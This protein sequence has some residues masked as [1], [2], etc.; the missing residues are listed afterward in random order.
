[1][2]YFVEVSLLCSV[3]APPNGA[4]GTP[5]CPTAPLGHCGALELPAPG[6]FESN[7]EPDGGPNDS[8]GIKFPYLRYRAETFLWHCGC[9]VASFRE[10]IMSRSDS[11]R[12]VPARPSLTPLPPEGTP[13]S[14]RVSI[15]PDGAPRS[16][17]PPGAPEADIRVED[18]G[19]I[20]DIVLDR[21]GRKNALTLP[22]YETLQ[23]FLR[24]ATIDERINVVVLR[25]AGGA[26][27]IGDDVGLVGAPGQAPTPSADLDLDAVAR[28]Q[29]QF[30]SSLAA[31][32]KPIVA[33]VNALAVGIGAM[34]LLYCDIVVASEF[35]A[36]EFS[37]VRLGMVPDPI[38]C[39]LLHSRIGLQRASEW[40]LLSERVKADEAL[41]LG[42]VNAVVPLENLHGSTRAR[43]EALAALPQRVARETKRMLHGP[44]RLVPSGF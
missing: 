14:S 17:R 27:C 5:W 34:M 18:S 7:E 13:R 28:A 38:A 16:S 41:R 9:V 29:S 23:G 25:S 15:P 21:R 1:M 33:A 6:R 10:L 32:R 8:I 4:T 37:S 12:P 39:A 40:L 42:L 35:A 30:L 3:T 20:R 2:R 22:M 36:F 24:D 19:S 26:F 31:F 44:L 43:A 11:V